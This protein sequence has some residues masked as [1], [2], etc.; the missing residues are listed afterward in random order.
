LLK[1]KRWAK[2]VNLSAGYRLAQYQAIGNAR[3]WKLGVT[4]D[5]NDQVTARATRSHD[6]RA[7][8]LDEL[9]RPTNT[10]FINFAD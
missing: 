10:T 5:F 2:N 3:T 9:F 1:D 7:P 4:W 8:G 6:F